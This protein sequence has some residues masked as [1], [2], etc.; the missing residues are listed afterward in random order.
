MA[1]N[2]CVYMITLNI[3][4]DVFP[5]LYGFINGKILYV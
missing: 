1:N 5:D 3:A 4:H 2:I